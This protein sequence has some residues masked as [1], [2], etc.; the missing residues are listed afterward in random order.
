[1]YLADV[2]GIDTMV[3]ADHVLQEGF[4][5]RMGHD[6]EPVMD[7]LLASGALGQKNGKGFY[8]YIQDASGRR[9]RQPA[10][11]ARAL[12]VE[13]VLERVEVSDE[14]I[15]DR[16][17]IPLC[18][19]AVRCLED[20]IVETPEEID[21]GLLLGIGF[22]RFRGGALRYIDTQGL[23][24]FARKAEAHARHG[25]LYQLTDDF[26]ARLAAGRGYF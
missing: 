14:E 12:I 20:G 6:G 10:E 22:P 24:V 2:I 4:P 1:A 21:M 9:S 8:E 26:R 25:G 15:V 5:E 7:A 11:A 19:E 13:R 17:M 16:L 18:L 23:E 3:H